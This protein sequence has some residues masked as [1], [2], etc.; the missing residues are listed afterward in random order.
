MCASVCVRRHG[1]GAGRRMRMPEVAERDRCT[2]RRIA[3][4]RGQVTGTLVS[5][6]PPPPPRRALRARSR[7]HSAARGASSGSALPTS[8]ERE[9]SSGGFECTCQC[10]AAVSD[11]ASDRRIVSRLSFLL[12]TVAWRRVRGGAC[13]L[14]AATHPSWGPRT[15]GRGPRLRG[16]CKGR[17]E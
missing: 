9:S 13:G 11:C 1:R 12:S 8:E 6:V 15:R 16:A 7:A 4:C 5:D 2:C 14:P 3:V 10:S 17:G